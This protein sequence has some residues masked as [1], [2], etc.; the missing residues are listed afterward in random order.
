MISTM[1]WGTE[2][3]AILITGEYADSTSANYI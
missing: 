2:K 1:P 3:Y